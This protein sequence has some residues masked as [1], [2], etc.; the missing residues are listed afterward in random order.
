MENA[1]DK[2]F[3]DSMFTCL[4]ETAVDSETVNASWKIYSK[5]V[6]YVKL[7]G[8]VRSEAFQI[9]RGVR[10]G[11]PLSLILVTRRVFQSYERNDTN[12]VVVSPWALTKT[13]NPSR[14]HDVC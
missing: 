2:V 14:I 7:G 1:F 5:Q 11:D 8:D 9:L 4:T 12:A 13:G 10:Q 3:H 6:A